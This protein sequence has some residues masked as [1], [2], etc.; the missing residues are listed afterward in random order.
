MGMHIES[1]K[2]EQERTLLLKPKEPLKGIE[3]R[4]PRLKSPLTSIS[5]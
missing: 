5:N 3:V 4:K 1:G 2:N